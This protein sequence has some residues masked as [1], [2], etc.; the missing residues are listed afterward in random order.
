MAR[1]CADHLLQTECIR[2][3]LQLPYSVCK[4]SLWIDAWHNPPCRLIS[5]PAMEFI[6]MDESA[7]LLASLRACVRNKDLQTAML[8]HDQILHNGLLSACSDALVCMYAQCSALGKARDLFDMHSSR[9]PFTWTAL[10]AGFVKNGQDQDALLFYDRMQHEGLPP[11]AVTFNCALK[12]CGNVKAI[13]KGEEIHDAIA[14]QGLLKTNIKLGNALVGM[15]AKCGFLAKARQVLKELRVRD[16]ITWTL[17]IAGYVEHG[18]GAQ[19]F[20]CFEEMRSEGFL[21]SQVTYGC[22]LRACGSLRA[23]DEG[24]VIHEEIAKQGWLKT[25]SV[26][27]NALV[28]MYAKCGALAKA[29]SVLNELPVRNVVSW[30]T[31]IAGHA[32]HGEDEQAIKCYEEMQREG[33]SPNAVTFASILKV[34]GNLKSIGRGEEIHEKIAKQGLVKDNIVLGNALVDFYIK[35]G[36]LP[37]AGK[38]LEELPTSS[39]ISWN[40]LITR[41]AH[42]VEGEQALNCFEQMRKKG[43]SPDAVTYAGILKAIGSIKALEKGESV[44]DE[45]GKQGLLKSDIVLGTALVDMY[46]KCGVLTKAHQVLEKLPIRDVISWTALIAG[47]S[48]HGE[49]E[50]ALTCFEEMQR[51]GFSP[52]AVTF[53]CSLKACGSIRALAKGEEI[54]NEIFKRRLLLSNVMLGNALL[55][56]YARC[57]ALTK[58]R[59]VLEELPIRNAVSW[60]TVIARCVEL[61]ED[62]QALKCFEQMQRE[63]FSPDAVTVAC[64]LKGCSSMGAADKGEKIHDEIVRQ[65]VLGNDIM[66]GTALLDMYAKCGAAHK[67]RRVLENLPVRDVV[68]WTALIAGL[69]HQGEGAQAMECFE[70]MQHEGVSPN[71]ATFSCLLSACSRQGLVEDAMMCFRDMDSRYGTKPDMQHYSCM[72]HVFGR[73]GHLDKAVEVIERMPSFNNDVWAALIVACRKWGDVNIGRWAFEQ[74]TQLLATNVL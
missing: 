11:N 35:C 28:D 44:H 20:S 26:L 58:A 27:G 69:I 9:D 21:P 19:A 1:R 3:I 38:V 47:Y 70:R 48:E 2:G 67:A 16:V 55:D 57:N 8:I 34:C 10:I 22:L 17:L 25:N 61:G 29:R 43:I 71:G 41:Y 62:E 56:M 42:Q 50:Q 14:Q 31:L 66:V 73:A 33:L 74:S 6:A 24:K 49:G 36:A 7:P 4:T 5:S 53:I 60:N 13:D 39:V 72:V 51:E 45:I 12:A 23:L 68:S 59:K 64:I 52:N 15:Y 18:D 32:E 40:A 30:N 65:G 46:A 63:G 37:K 54:H